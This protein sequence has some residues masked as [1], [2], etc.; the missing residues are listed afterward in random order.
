M[1]LSDADKE[2]YAKLKKAILGRLD[3]D[4]DK[5][6]LAAR[7]QLS[8]R[9]LQEGVNSIDEQARDL[10]KLLDQASPGFPSAMHE[11]SYAFTKSTPY[12][13]MWHFN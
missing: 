5:H 4:T 3:P 8:H 2:T 12:L 1:S 7:D 10:E 9:R 6:R 11:Q 13:T